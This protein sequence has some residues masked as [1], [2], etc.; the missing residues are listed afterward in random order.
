M[1]VKNINV[2]KLNGIDITAQTDK[3]QS[4]DVTFSN[5]IKDEISIY[6][7][8]EVVFTKNFHTITE[9]LE[10]LIDSKRFKIVGNCLYYIGSK[11]F[12]KPLKVAYLYNDTN[13][14]RLN[15]NDLTLLNDLDIKMI[16]DNIKYLEFNEGL[17]DIIP[18]D[19]NEFC[20]RFV[21]NLNC[22]YK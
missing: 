21:T 20:Q 1:I 18:N 17:I 8:G 9:K 10:F 12:K 4:L 13:T 11:N 5:E 6:I 7:N 16:F 22:K 15:R 3:G 2:T 19:L 14:I